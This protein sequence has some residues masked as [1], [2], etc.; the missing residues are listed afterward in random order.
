MDPGAFNYNPDANIDDGECEPFVYG[1]TDNTM[2]NF[3]PA[4]NAEYD[5]SN[6]EPYIYGCT[7]PSMLN[8]NSSANTEDFSCIRYI[9]GCTDPSAL[10]YDP[11]ANTDND[12]CIE[13]LEGC[14]DAQAVNYDPLANTATESCYYSAGCAVG[15]IYYLPNGCFEWV[16]S[17]DPYCCDNSWDST[18][19]T[20]Y[21]YCEDGWDG[22]LTVDDLREGKISFYPNPT[23]DIV[24]IAANSTVDA[25]VYNSSGKKVLDVTN[26]NML[27]LSKY[28][29]GIYYVRVS[30]NE[31]IINHKIIKN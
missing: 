11:L 10:N 7:D 21:D 28:S 23:S 20:L 4:A 12:S 3:N 13:I 24:N 27:D 16:I 9:Y 15:D 19:S 30:Y 22:P 31:F 5:P 8:Y 29:N 26:V 18:C 14:T 17:V 1:C 2:F 6:C 25:V